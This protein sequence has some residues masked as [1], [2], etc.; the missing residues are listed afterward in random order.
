MQT[1][2]RKVVASVRATNRRRLTQVLTD[3][4]T[5][6][7]QQLT[8]LTGATLVVLLAVLGV[9][10]VRIGQLTWLHLFLGLVLLGPIAV[11]L[12]STGYRF[13]RYYTNDAA[14]R[15][16][17][18]PETSLRMLAPLVV[19]S[20]LVVFISGMLLLLAG[21]RGRDRLL[22]LHKISFIVWLVFTGLHVLGHL[23]RMARDLRTIPDSPGAAGRWIALAGSLVAGVV[24]AVALIPQFAAWTGR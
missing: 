7:N 15:S 20:T 22:P 6:G 3:G 13:V 10:I 24:V 2:E 16:Q 23:P 19:A 21:P 8:S 11:K 18:P 14:Y 12:T 5:R 4:G 1:A 17:G 9:T